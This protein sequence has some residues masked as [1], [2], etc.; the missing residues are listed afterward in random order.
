M[1]FHKWTGTDS[2][3]AHEHE[4]IKILCQKIKDWSD[5]NSIET[6]LLT[7]FYAGGEEIDALVILPTNLVVI[8]LK[9]GSGKITGGENGDWICEKNEDEKFE[10]NKNRKNP[11]MQARTKRWAV[12]NYLD[13]RKEQIFPMQKASQMEFGHTNSYI[14]FDGDVD[15]D[16]EQ[17]PVKVLPWFDVLSLEG[18]S[19]KI[20]SIRSDVLSLTSEESWLIPTLLDLRNEDE[21][22]NDDTVIDSK[23]DEDSDSASSSSKHLDIITAVDREAVE[24]PNNQK[25]NLFQGVFTG[26]DSDNSL[27]SIKN[28]NGEEFKVHLND[29]F[30]SV[31]NDLHRLVSVNYKIIE[32]DEIEINLINVEVSNNNIYLKDE[33]SSLIV[34]EPEWL[35]NV[36]SLTEFDFCE[37][38]LFNNRYSIKHQN[39]FMIR[40]SIV[41][42][43]FEQILKEPD[44]H[45]KLREEL[46]NCFDK[47]ALEFALADIDYNDMEEEFVRPHLRA[48][49]KHRKDPNKSLSSI[50]EDD[51]N[52]ERFI[53]NPY[54]GLKGKIDAV[55]REKDG[56]RA[57]ELKTGKSWGGKVKDGHAFQAQAYSLLMEFKYGKNSVLPPVVIYSGDYESVDQLNQA[58]PNSGVSI[59][60]EVAF[61]YEEKSHVLKLRNK[62]V[63]ADYLFSLDYETNANKC[64]KCMQKEICYEIFQLEAEHDDSNIH[65]FHFDNPIENYSSKEKQFFN[66]YN[67]LLTQEYRVIKESQGQYISKSPKERVDS[68]KCIKITSHKELANNLYLLSCRNESELRESDMC[69]LS[70]E[71]GPVFGECNEVFIQDVTRNS[72]TIKS[73]A[74][75]EFIPKY[76]DLFSSEAVFEKNFASLYEL[77]NNPN[78]SNLKN[79]YLSGSNP[80]ENQLID[81]EDYDSKVNLHDTQKKCMQL[82]LG[83]EDFLLIQGP[84]GTGKTL[85]ISLIINQLFKEQ[86]SVLIACYTHRAIDEVVRKI[87]ENAPEVSIFRLG[88]RDT[89]KNGD[90]IDLESI[91]NEENN[92]D[93]R[94]EKAKSI[95]SKKPVYIGTTHAWLS[96][97]YDH[98]VTENLF[99]IAIIDE[100]AQVVMPNAL[101]VIR[102]AKKFI[103]VGD[104][105]QLPPVIQSSEAKKLTNTIFEILYNRDYENSNIKLMLD[106]QHRMAKPIAEFISQEFYDGKLHTSNEVAD[107]KLEFDFSES[108]LFEILNPDKQLTLVNIHTSPTENRKNTSPN[109]VKIIIDI[110][111]EMINNGVDINDIGII[112]P[113]RAQVA[114]IR[115]GI[116]QSAIF[117]SFESKLEIKKLVD[118]VDR[119][120]GDER[121]VMMFSLSLTSK[122]IGSILED[123]R[124]INVAISR[125]KKKFIGVGNWTLVDNH[126]TLKNLREFANNNIGAQ[127]V[128]F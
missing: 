92:L 62:L 75:I 116:E 24:I 77:I 102:L 107:N 120:Q 99:D 13:V 40:G 57:I 96:G 41:H 4:Q 32:K 64:N 58:N 103:L 123:V 53:I 70:N 90:T 28:A 10:I 39:K 12:I 20:N 71:G 54:L 74:S 122:E 23:E 111:S 68:G 26:L 110:L 55:I 97:K 125:A 30:Q 108:S 98:L 93:D 37:R 89:Q 82:S 11:L 67:E 118:T 76:L 33:L 16:K 52:T 66:L 27:I 50:G 85:T 1:K 45:D 61:N 25:M 22:I 63:L 94:V 36:T 105:K 114:S 88:S 112:A 83:L 46:K 47:R 60:K 119:F 91:I 8:D 115:R 73:R 87:R 72:V 124:R 14:V 51:V 31:A 69:L 19:E 128:K 3:F 17:V 49:Y 15:W 38:S 59:S 78:L 104:H 127:V 9:S 100:A 56:S 109:E 21:E 113:Y 42:E 35:I 2:D 117:N 5:K 80:R 95:I 6:H 84:P 48:L 65:L 126:A 18:L 106:V 86:R 34:I 29:A 81:I 121:D 44:E 7:N 79:I 43:V 101:G